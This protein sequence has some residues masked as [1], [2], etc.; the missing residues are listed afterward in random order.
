M[1]KTVTEGAQY[2]QQLLGSYA[3]FTRSLRGPLV[4]FALL[5]RT[6]H[7]IEHTECHLRRTGDA[8]AQIAAILL[9]DRLSGRCAD[10]RLSGPRRVNRIL[11]AVRSFFRHAAAVGQLDPE[12]L[13]VVYDS[14]DSNSG[15][16]AERGGRRQWASARHRLSEPDSP[17]VNA[18]GE[19]MVGLICAAGNACNR[20]IV[21]AMW[22]MGLRRGELAGMLR[23][24]VHFVPD[25]SQ[26]GYGFRGTHLHVVL[27][28]YPNGAWAKS[29][30]DGVP[31]SRCRAS[32]ADV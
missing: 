5:H 24:D 8:T 3:D 25:A 9:K 20:F 27:R 10:C 4:R 14:F 22:R 19:D 23:S 7:R 28:T 17:I 6:V 11:A 29:H 32:R 21:V 16:E 15:S 18:A 12:V 13:G 1:M 26:L 2:Q 30:P 31:A